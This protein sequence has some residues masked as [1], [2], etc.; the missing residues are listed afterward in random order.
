MAQSSPIL[1]LLDQRF[2]SFKQRRLSKLLRKQQ[3]GSGLTNLLK[4]A[5]EV[6]L[7]PLNNSFDSDKAS[8]SEKPGLEKQTSL[9]SD[10]QTHRT[11]Q[12]KILIN[13]ST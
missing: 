11:F 4:Q 10:A 9:T 2:S 8:A 1:P 12:P 7:G 13:N 6:S 3:F 5:D